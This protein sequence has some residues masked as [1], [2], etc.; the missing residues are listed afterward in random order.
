[1][2][3]ASPCSFCKLVELGSAL[4]VSCRHQLCFLP[5]CMSESKPDAG[6]E[7]CQSIPKKYSADAACCDPK[8][9]HKHC[10]AQKR[11]G[12]SG[13]TIMF[14]SEMLQMAHQPLEGLQVCPCHLLCQPADTCAIYK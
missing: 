11:T 13:C 12:Q 14:K 5:C 6:P 2:Q 3:D 7:V 1:M 10:D 9:D 4:L 8:F